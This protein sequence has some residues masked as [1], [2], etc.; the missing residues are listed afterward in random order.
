MS[1]FFTLKPTKFSNLTYCVF[2]VL[3]CFRPVVDNMEAVIEPEGVDD[4]GGDRL[5][6]IQVLS[7][8]SVV[9][10]K[11]ET[12]KMLTPKLKPIEIMSL[13]LKPINH[14]AQAVDTH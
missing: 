11:E 5:A 1:Y 12:K 13:K 8:I 4:D 10:N 6:V 3:L 9:G 2:H 14:Q 7:C